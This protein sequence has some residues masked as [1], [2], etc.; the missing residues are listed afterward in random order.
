MKQYFAKLKE[1][2]PDNAFRPDTLVPF[3]RSLHC[4]C[5][6]LLCPLRLWVAPQR[7]CNR[8]SYRVTVAVTVAVG[9]TNESHV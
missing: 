5:T 4:L 7:H 8:S 6:P 3:L 9:M 2:E 1:M